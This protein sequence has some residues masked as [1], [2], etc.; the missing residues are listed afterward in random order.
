MP[1]SQH[2]RKTMPNSS[3]HDFADAKAGIFRKVAHP[4]DDFF[5]AARRRKQ[6]FALLAPRDSGK[7]S[8]LPGSTPST[9]RAGVDFVAHSLRAA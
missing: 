3:P 8:L 7:N 2:G 4:Q 5:R 1:S 6:V 9:S